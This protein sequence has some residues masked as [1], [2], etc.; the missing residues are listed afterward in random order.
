MF[1]PK[2]ILHSPISNSEALEDFIEQCLVDKVSLIAIVG[3]GCR[4][5]EDT[6]D[7]LIIGTAHDKSRYICTTAHSNE[8]FYTV[9]EM[10]ASWDEENQNRIDEIFL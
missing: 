4:E 5:L 10:V 3:E 2:I 7:W 1:A 6:I 8:A 9:F